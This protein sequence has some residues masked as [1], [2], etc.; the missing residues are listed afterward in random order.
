MP[1]EYSPAPEVEDVARDLIHLY[2][3]HLATVRI[4]YVFA[5][6]ALKEKGK[7]V[8]G[9]AKKVSGLNAYIAA[10]DRGYESSQPEEFFVIEIHRGS[11]LQLSEKQRKA[12][13]DHEL[14]HLD[15]DLDTNKLSLK[16]HDL[17]EFN[18]IVRRYG[19]WQPDVEFF[20]R[21]A[22]E[23]ERGLFEEEEGNRE[24]TQV[25]MQ[26]GGKSYDITER[27]DAERRHRESV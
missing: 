27:L 4:D 25:T 22:R 13:C 17:E 12:L 8:L 2:H 1:Q 9:R 19:L 26:V 5:T 3:T 14:H 16:P 11:W 24:Y 10:K 15:V 18:A 21:A 7:I 6:E 20:V 23:K